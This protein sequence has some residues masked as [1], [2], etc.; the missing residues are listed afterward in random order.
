MVHFQ[1]DT[2][3]M[4][5]CSY[6]L[7]RTSSV[8]SVNCAPSPASL[9]QAPEERVFFRQSWWKII[10]E[11]DL[12][13][14][15]GH[16]HNGDD[17]EDDEALRENVNIKMMRKNIAIE[18]KAFDFKQF[19]QPLTLYVFPWGAY[20]CQPNSWQHVHFDKACRA[21]FYCSPAL[22]FISFSW[23]HLSLHLS[24]A[25]NS[26]VDDWRQTK[27]PFRADKIGCLLP[28]CVDCIYTPPGNLTRLVVKKR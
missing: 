8:S 27:A 24:T 5:S 11:D 7:C 9:W 6:T 17:N 25:H 12:E 2:Q 26:F 19:S 4:H 1:E 16:D 21:L 28:D 14:N 20:L 10:E 22:C 15:K 13:Y 18:V 3:W 23:F